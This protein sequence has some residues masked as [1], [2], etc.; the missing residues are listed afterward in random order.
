MSKKIPGYGKQLVLAAILFSFGTASYWLVY[1]KQPKDEAK[2]AEEKKVFVLKDQ[3]VKALEISGGP[4]PLA[5]TL[6]CLSL[7]DGL[8]KTEDS[9]KWELTSPLKTKAEDTTVNSLLKNFANLASSEI[10]DLSA[11]TPE[12]RQTLL[13]DYGL[14]AEMRKD[15][16]TKKIRFTLVDGRVL[17]AYF[18]VKHPIG[19]DV[20]S[21]LETTTP[22]ENRVFMVPEWQISIFN[23]R[24]SYFRDKKVFS[25]VDK[26]INQFTISKS[27]KI[28]G[29]IE[30]TKDGASQKWALAF[31]NR[32]VAGD[33][34]TIEG[35]LSG[36]VFLSAKDFIAERKD[37]PEGKKALL[38]MTPVFVLEL[39]TKTLKKYLRLFEKPQESKK[40]KGP[41]IL[42]GT[43]D[44]QDPVFE[45]EPSALEKL[46]KP[47]DEFRVVK[48]IGITDRYALNSLEI[49]LKGPKSFKQEVLKETTGAWK[50]GGVESARG[51]VE[52]L[53]DRLTS[54]I[55]KGFSGPAPG[56]ETLVITFG[57][58][59]KEPLHQIQ[60]WKQG[61][62]L[63]ARDLTSA[64]KETVELMND[65]SMQLPWD[66]RLL[67]DINFGAKH[68]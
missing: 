63:Y 47:F 16:K 54:K 21:L 18:G 64:E 33:Q 51:R 14:S 4:A 65:F 45:V 17:T 8:C 61:P 23:Q 30:A 36:V 7:K 44:D 38:G 66:E 56:A 22:D 34:D 68:E 42:Y 46:E 11:E 57:K 67:K 50:I 35:F 28:S 53:L 27:Q 62:G 39:K 20:F 41:V 1:S 29:K 37:S 24:T 43:I 26:E 2:K 48:L 15:P 25:V 32:K 9:S 10:V 6:E 59:P 3:K 40:P 49:E 58:S 13:K 31:G 52:G 12:K 19:E 60:F 5:V 55:V